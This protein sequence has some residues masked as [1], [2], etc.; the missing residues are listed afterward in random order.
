M[1]SLQD[2]ESLDFENLRTKNNVR[3]LHR[4]V[5]FRVSK[6][7]SQNRLGSGY[8]PRVSFAH[9]SVW[10]IVYLTLVF[11]VLRSSYCTVNA[12]ALISLTLFS[13]HH[14]IQHDVTVNLGSIRKVSAF[15]CF[16]AQQDDECALRRAFDRAVAGPNSQFHRE[17]IV[18]ASDQESWVPTLYLYKRRSVVYPVCIQTIENAIYSW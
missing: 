10:R 17:Q 14:D 12:R 4:D 18:S 1:L 6:V 11:E 16:N 15:R 9:R 13:R 2:L 3:H 7:Q 8:L 5:G